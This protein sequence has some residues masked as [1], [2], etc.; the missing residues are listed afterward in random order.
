MNNETETLNKELDFPVIDA[1]EPEPREGRC[2]SKCLV[3]F[4]GLMHIF[5]GF[6]IGF[7]MAQF[8][9]FFKFFIR[10]KF[11]EEIPVE[12]YDSVQSLINTM[13]IIGGTVCS[14]VSIKII[15]TQSL[16]KIFYF[17]SI[18]I[19]ITTVVQLFAPLYLFYACRFILG[20]FVV[21]LLLIEPLLVNH[22]CPSEFIGPIGSMFSLSIALGILFSSSVSSDFSQEYWYLFICVPIPIEIFRILVSCVMFP[23]KSPY[24]TFYQIAKKKSR[25]RSN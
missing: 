24:F 18:T 2:K 14:I 15:E 22:C 10:G 11:K 9:T 20:F 8:S 17:S 6:Y 23:L 25:K 1:E 4:F 19:I 21:F 16:I 3:Y 7:H 13:F 12:D 5:S